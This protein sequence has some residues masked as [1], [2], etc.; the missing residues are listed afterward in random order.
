[1]LAIDKT[2]LIAEPIREVSWTE[3]CVAGVESVKP[4]SG[5]GWSE[6]G[7]TCWNREPE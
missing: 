7:L 3:R 1:M 5:Y 4:E 2:F 6:L